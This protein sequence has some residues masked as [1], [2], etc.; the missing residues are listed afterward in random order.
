[1]RLIDAEAFE[2]YI[3]EGLETALTERQGKICDEELKL[4]LDVTEGLI[5]DIQEQP[6]VD[7]VK[8][9]HWDKVT[10]G[11]GGHQCSLCNEY[12]PSFKNGKENLSKY[13]PNYISIRRKK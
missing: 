6:T 1:M 2:K 11:R 12:A 9:A 7:L 8:H 10:N 3:A 5:K 4:V 13:C